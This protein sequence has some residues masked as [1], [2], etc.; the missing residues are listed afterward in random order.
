MHM[1][2][3]AYLEH[4]RFALCLEYPQ[5]TRNDRCHC[6]S[7]P[8]LCYEYREGIIHK[9]GEDVKRVQD[10]PGVEGRRQLNYCGM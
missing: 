7:V 2:G 5:S 9:Y 4:M 1:N 6:H 10:S 8:K 3:Q